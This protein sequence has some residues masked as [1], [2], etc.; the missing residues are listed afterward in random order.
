MMIMF[1]LT[2]FNSRSSLLA[3]IQ[4]RPHLRLLHVRVTGWVTMSSVQEDT[5]ER[6]D[7]DFL[8]ALP[9]VRRFAIWAFGPDGLPALEI[10][11]YGDFSFQGRQP[12][13][14]LCRS[15][16]TVADGEGAASSPGPKFREVTPQDVRLW[17]LVQDNL[18]FLEACPEDYLLHQ[19]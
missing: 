16:D 5:V 10:L 13:I 18:D 15:Q 14:L 11:A 4:P 6:G 1:R 2:L 3:G 17:D 7:E 19:W 9:A 8:H 12:N